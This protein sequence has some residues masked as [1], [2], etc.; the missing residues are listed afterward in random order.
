MAYTAPY[1]DETGLHMP[2]YSDVRD[3]L[4]NRA[5]QI[6]GQDLYLD[7]DSLDYQHNSVFS[8]FIADSYSFTEI[9]Y[10]MLSPKYAVGTALDNIVK[11]NGL[12]RKKAS[13]ST[14]TLQ[15]RGNIGTVIHNGIV[16]DLSGVRWLLDDETVTFTS[17]IMVVSAT[18]EKLGAVEAPANSIKNI[19]TPTRGWLSCNN[20]ER[21]T[22][23][24]AVETDLE[25]RTRREKSTEIASVNMIGSLYSA[26]L[27]LDNVKTC[28]VVENDTNEVD[29]N[30]IPGHSVACVV[31]G[32]NI[33]EIAQIISQKKGPGCGTYGDITVPVMQ[34][35]GLTMNIS[36]FRPTEVT[37]NLE[38]PIIPST[39]FTTDTKA[40]IKKAI[41]DYFE[42]IKIGMDIQRGSIITVVSKIIDDVYNPEF[43]VSLPI[44]TAREN[45]ELSDTD[46]QI[47]FNEKAVLGE[48]SFIG[49]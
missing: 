14:V 21:A 5:R 18:C 46:T 45:E 16:A 41:E 28:Q 3:E 44:M 29:D 31:E 37:V 39:L 26:L 20:S 30:N 40:K 32:G 36:F 13:Y 9:A 6:H 15:L 35:T 49:V 43:K 25:L 48:L 17:E 24:S 42:N 12:T 47:S 19:I 33:S 34:I 11:L 4:N 8:M 10:Q 1:I 2:S 22:V 27:A 38:I 7:I 23:G